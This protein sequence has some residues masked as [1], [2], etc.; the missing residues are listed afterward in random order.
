VACRL[1]AALLRCLIT[2]YP[3]ANGV[4][5]SCSPGGPT[6]EDLNAILKTYVSASD[7]NVPLNHLHSCL[8]QGASELAYHISE[9]P[10]KLTLTEVGK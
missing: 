8:D 3:K 6:T 10:P 9:N 7:F 1:V 5:T 2:L 4:Q